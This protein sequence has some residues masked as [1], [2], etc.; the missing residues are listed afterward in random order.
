[1]GVGGVKF[2]RMERIRS[3]Q[4]RNKGVAHDLRRLRVL[5]DIDSGRRRLVHS[6][7]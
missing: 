4:A 5:G 2:L 7:E 1:M 6:A 3:Q